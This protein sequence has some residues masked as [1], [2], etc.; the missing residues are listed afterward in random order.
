[1]QPAAVSPFTSIL[2]CILPAPFFLHSSSIKN[3]HLYCSLGCAVTVATPSIATLNRMGSFIVYNRPR[4]ELGC[5]R[6]LP[7]HSISTPSNYI[8]R[9]NIPT[10]SSITLLQG[11]HVISPTIC[12]SRLDVA[13]SLQHNCFII[14][15]QLLFY[16]ISDSSFQHRYFITPA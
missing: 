4:S 16:S 12:L 11:K 2:Y 15:A 3:L 10:S 9:H 1:M 13:A 7:H 8:L 5:S 14:S 6:S